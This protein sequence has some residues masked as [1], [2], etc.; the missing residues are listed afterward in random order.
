[1]ISLD[2]LLNEYGKKAVDLIKSKVPVVTGKTRD[3][4]RYEVINTNDKISLLVFG[5][6]FF[7]SVETG[8]GPATKG[9]YQGFD[10]RLEEWLKAKGVPS[11]VGKTG[12]TYYFLGDK[13]ITAKGLS[14]AIN[15]E[16]DF[17]YQNG[18][19][20][21]YSRELDLLIE[22]LKKDIPQEFKKGIK[23]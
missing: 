1:M 22:E 23:V 11:K 3:S 9:G 19:Q 21:V 2:H 10:K 5:R 18:R 12:I 4:V 8:R 20:E 16:G 17:K 15:K 7:K 14:I 13:W 6:P